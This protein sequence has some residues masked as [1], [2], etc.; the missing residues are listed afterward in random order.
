MRILAAKTIDFGN[1]PVARKKVDISVL[2]LS[3]NKKSRSA[4]ERRSDKIMVT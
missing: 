4:S 2:E 3:I 1:R